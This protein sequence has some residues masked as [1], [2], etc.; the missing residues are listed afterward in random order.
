MKNAKYLMWFGFILFVI[1]FVF[2]FVVPKNDALY[3]SET[4][5]PLLSAASFIVVLSGILMQK[6]ELMLQRFEL[7][8][9]RDVY[10]DQNSLINIQTFETTFFNLINNFYKI[11][12]GIKFSNTHIVDNIYEGREGIRFIKLT[13]QSCFNELPKEVDEKKY[14]VKQVNDILLGEFNY[15]V[16]HYFK[17]IFSILNLIHINDSLSLERKTLYLNLF[18]SM[19]SSEEKYLLY[20]VG[21]T[22]YGE[23]IRNILTKY[24]PELRT[25]V[26]YDEI[27]EIYRI[28]EY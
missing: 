7:K 4:I 21:H 9:T 6:E 16:D 20:C 25:F 10:K 3:I 22:E 26:E 5:S 14:I 19:I 17:T 24:D 8:E 27:K 12:E 2:P 28:M 15:I 13:L 11:I 18:L 1:A 23:V